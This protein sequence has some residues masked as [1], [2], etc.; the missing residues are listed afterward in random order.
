MSDGDDQRR[1]SAILAADM[2]GYTRRMEQDADGTVA[3]WKAARSDIIDPTISGHAGHIVKHTGDGFLAEF[4][5][6]QAAVEC[7]VAMQERLAVGRLDFRMGIDLEDIIDDGE[8]IHGE[9]VNIA[10]R[11]EALA[12]PG[13]ICI[14]GAVHNRVLNRLDHQFEDMGEIEVKNVARPV[15]VYRV[16]LDGKATETSRR[17]VMAWKWPALV[18]AAILLAI[19][20]G[21]TWWW[22]QPDFEPADRSKF[23]YKLPEKPSIAVLPF[24]NLSGDPEQDYL[25]DG[26]TENIIAVL[27]GSPDL[28]VIARNSSFT[29]KNKPVQVQEVAE[30]FG[31]R[32]VLEG[33]VQR[34]GDRIR[35]TAQLVDAVDGGHLWAERYDRE[36]EGL[37]LFDLQDDISQRILEEM[38]VKLTLG[39]QAREWRELSGDHESYRLMVQGRAHFLEWSKKGH[40][41]AE[42]I[43]S[44]LYKRK[45]N[46]AIANFL[47]GWIHWQKVAINI[48]KNQKKDMHLARKF[49]EKSLSLIPSVNPYL[50]L[51]SLDAYERKHDSAIANVDRAL[52]LAPAGG[53][54]H[55]IGGSTK[56]VSGQ[57]AEGIR[58]MKLGMCYEPDYPEYVSRHLAYALIRDGIRQI[59][60]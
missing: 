22:Q 35:L 29:Y 9:G 26:L 5:T 46:S 47:M 18:A 24:D 50:I 19:A 42:K 37:N 6:V 58:L 27:S 11:I 39:E 2:V 14:S 57:P 32:Y 60:Y 21:G 52:E 8:D 49:A 38:H 30:R 10:A 3:A 51:A 54:A 59:T 55:N 1:L 13:G 4:P 17:P 44:D 25:G 43:W 53:D 16:L 28:F 56:V 15:R 33:S 45:P 40:R 7:A 31:V 48:S 41:T 36:L 20:A 12:E 23:A 34:S